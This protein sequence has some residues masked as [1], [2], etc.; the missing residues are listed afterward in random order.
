MKLFDQIQDPK[1]KLGDVVRIT[2]EDETVQIDSLSIDDQVA[3]FN[4]HVKAFNSLNVIDEQISSEN[5]NFIDKGNYVL[6]N[7]YIKSITSNLKME[8]IPIVS[9]ESIATLSQTALNHHIALEGFIGDM[10]KKIKEIFNKI[11]NSI[12]EFFKTYFTRLGRLKNKINNLLEVLKETDKDIKLVTLE[13]VPGGLASKY[14]VDGN[15]DVSTITETYDS[16]STLLNSFN[17]VNKRAEA[18]S[19]KDILDK[20]FVAKIIKLK[21]EINTANSQIDNNKNEQDKLGSV[22][23]FIPG[24]DDRA[25]NKELNNTNDSLEKDAIS[26]S[27]EIDNSK[28]KISDI[29]SKEGDIDLDDK[30]GEEAQREFN[31]FIKSLAE[32]LNKVKGKQLING[33]TITEIKVDEN[34]GIEIETNENKETPSSVTL[35]DKATLIKLL[36]DISQGIEQSEKLTAIYGKIND[37]IMENMNKVDKL[38]SDINKIPEDSLGKYKKLLNNKIK[39]R[40][41]LAKTFFNNYNKICKNMLEMSMDTGDGVVLYSVLSLKHFG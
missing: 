18:F 13:K 30:K 24:T 12:K 20:D 22:K 40:L 27:N 23:K 5:Y 15:I 19:S 16:L 32:V 25:K 21:D 1:P 38:I 3:D 35:E 26:K 4:N 33:K 14:P 31:D 10:W 17:E 11:Y 34:S 2:T 28:N 7:E 36:T 41:N 6:Y 8:H 39:V 29:T 37:K 9:Q